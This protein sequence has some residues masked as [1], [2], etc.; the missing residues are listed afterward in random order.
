MSVIGGAAEPQAERRDRGVGQ[1]DRL[2]DSIINAVGHGI[3][4]DVGIEADGAAI[5]APAQFID[6][7]GAE[8]TG[9]AEGTDVTV[10]GAVI[11]KIRDAGALRGLDARILL[12]RVIDV[13]LIF[14]GYVLQQVA[15]DLLDEDWRGRGTFETCSGGVVGFRNE[16]EQLFDDGVGDGGA[17][18][19]G[20]NSAVD[21]G[22]K[23]L[24]EALIADEEEGLVSAV[25]EVR[26]KHRTAE[27]STGLIAVQGGHLYPYGVEEVAGID[28]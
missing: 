22:A 8:L 14:P 27:R 21:G 2:G 7:V 3:G 11:A 20:G 19:I 6:D 18:R 12:P 9:F 15:C 10:R 25:V 24:I 13:Q 28:V 4:G 17:L 5:E 1:T 23:G 26:H 16:R